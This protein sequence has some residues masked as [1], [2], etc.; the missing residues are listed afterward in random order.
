MQRIWADFNR[1]GTVDGE[2]NVIP[3]GTDDSFNLREH[4]L[5]E[6]ARAVFHEE[7]SLEA[8]G[9]LQV[10]QRTSDGRPYWYAVLDL[11]TLKHLDGQP[12]T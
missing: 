12:T 10:R 5:C 4:Q 7:G 11:A 8:E 2:E 1:L 3:L 6:G 9:T